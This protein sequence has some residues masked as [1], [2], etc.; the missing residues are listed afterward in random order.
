ML[1]RELEGR[2]RDMISRSIY[3]ARGWAFSRGEATVA[4]RGVSRRNAVGVNASKGINVLGI[5]FGGG[6]MI[7][8][9]CVYV[10]FGAEDIAMWCGG[11]QRSYR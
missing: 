3:I 2:A 6:C 1:R 9:T 5:F 7:S 8:C 11:Q 4:T 10:N